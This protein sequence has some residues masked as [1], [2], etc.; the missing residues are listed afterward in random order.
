MNC[1]ACKRSLSA[2][3][4]GD[5]SPR[6]SL[7]VSG[8]LAACAECSA[9]SSRLADVDAALANLSEIQPA[10]GF[11]AAVMSKIASLPAPERPRRSL[12]WL[13]ALMLT[14]W[15]ILAVLNA[16]HV[17]HWQ[18]PLAVTAAFAADFSIAAQTLYRL[19]SHF[20]IGVW[21][22]AGTGA[23]IAILIPVAMAVRSYVARGGALRGAR[24]S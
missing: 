2:Y 17:L 20:H 3:N 24:V 10:A 4:D 8:H 18:R 12:W 23:E 16:A 21:A 19:A 9:Y 6:E 5:L 14:E 7:L 13:P 11:T 1:S 15:L 22:V